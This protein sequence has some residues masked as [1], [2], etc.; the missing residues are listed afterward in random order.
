MLENRW[1]VKVGVANAEFLQPFSLKR[2]PRARGSMQMQTLRLLGPLPT[3]FG[4]QWY[5]LA[6][7]ERVLRAVMFRREGS[8][9]SGEVCAECAAKPW[10]RA[11]VGESSSERPLEAFVSGGLSVLPRPAK[12]SCSCD[13]GRLH[14]F[15]MISIAM[16]VCGSANVR[17]PSPSSRAVMSTAGTT[18]INYPDELYRENCFRN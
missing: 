11:A 16:C 3:Y 7:P 8:A 1:D 18:K 17:P 9:T 15:H 6:N 2:A 5:A 10:L 12:R 14:V 4:P 13:N